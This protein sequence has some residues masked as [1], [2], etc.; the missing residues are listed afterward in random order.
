MYK[1]ACILSGEGAKGAWQ[2]SVLCHQNKRYDLMVGVSSGA[3]NA[4]LYAILGTALADFTSQ[5]TK[6]SD[7]FAFNWR[8]LF[9]SGMFTPAPMMKRISDAIVGLPFQTKVVFPTICCKTRQLI[10]HTF[11][12]G[13]ICDEDDARVITSAGAIAGVIHAVD[14]M[15]DGGFRTLCPIK[16]AIDEGCDEID[17]II[18]QCPTVPP[19]WPN[20]DERKFLN[21]ANFG[22]TIVGT[23][24]W[25]I[26]ANDIQ[27]AIRCNNEL[28]KM[29]V[30]INCIFPE[31]DLGS[32]LAFNKCADMANLELHPP[33]TISL[34]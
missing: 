24:L 25:Q 3:C 5:I 2:S 9:D 34:E 26:M 33:V 12:E 13:H 21:F 27:Y 28:G 16:M 1:R 15:V 10:F 11:E 18:G 30:K 23:M 8:F 7:L 22:V 14:G 32:P 20:P 31:I 29:K 4:A 6:F 17:V 19:E